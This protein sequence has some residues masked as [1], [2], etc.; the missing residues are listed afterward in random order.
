MRFFQLAAVVALDAAADA[1]AARVVGHQHHIAAGQR[2]E[3]GE[4][5]ALVAALFL[6]HLDQQLLAFADHILD[7]RLAGATHWLEVLSG[8]FLKGK[9]PWR[10]SP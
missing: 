7:A 4:R 1:A 3:G 8:D 10:S 6:F 9:K 2:D 5:R